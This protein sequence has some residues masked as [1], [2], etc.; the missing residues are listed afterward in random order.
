MEGIMAIQ[1]IIDEH[2]MPDAGMRPLKV[3][4]EP[5]YRPAP[6][7]QVVMGGKLAAGVRKHSA[8]LH[9]ADR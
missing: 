1:K 2:G 4:V 7:P 5:T 3:A 8:N 6:Q 9:S